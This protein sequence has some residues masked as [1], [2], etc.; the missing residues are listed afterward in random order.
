[1]RRDEIITSAV[2][3]MLRTTEDMVFIKDTDLVYVGASRAFADLVGAGSPE[4]LVGKTD[5]ELFSD[6][7]LAHRYTE[8]D[9]RLLATGGALEGY[10]EPIASKDGKPRYSRTSKYLLYDHA[11]AVIGLYG[12]GREITREYEAKLHYERELSALFELPEDALAAALFDITGWRVVDVRIRKRGFGITA[13]YTSIDDYVKNAAEAVAEEGEARAFFRSISQSGMQALYDS[14]KRNLS[15][16]YLRHTK[17]GETRWAQDDLHFLIDPVNGHLCVVVVLRDVE[18]KKRAER[19]LVRAAKQ[20]AL[21][22]L[23]NR[24]ET[25]RRIGAFL[26]QEGAHGTHAFFMIDIDNFKAVN[27]TFGHRT[28]DRVLTE[29]GEML[30]GVFRDTDIVGRIGGDEFFALMKNVSDRKT[31]LKKACDLVES[32]QYVCAV[33]QKRVELS[34]S[35]G[36]SDY[37]DGKTLEDL[38]AEADAALYRVKSSGKNGYECADGWQ[39][40][41]DKEANAAEGSAVHLKTL[42]ENIAGEVFQ[43]EVVGD[44]VRIVYESRGVIGKQGDDFWEKIVPEDR[45]RLK[46]AMYVAA[47]ADAALDDTYRVLGADGEIE[48]RY[49][50]GSKLPDSRDGVCRMINVAIDVTSQKR[51]ENALRE[52]NQIIEFAMKNTD[53]NLWFYDVATRNCLLSENCKRIHGMGADVLPNYPESIIES[54]YVREDCVEEVRE[55]YRRLCEYGEGFEMDAW[56]RTG[57]GGS[58]W[59]ERVCLA[60]VKDENGNVKT[61]IGIGKNVTEMRELENKYRAFQTYRRLAGKNTI[62]SFRMNL[63]TNWCGDCVSDKPSVQSMNLPENL[64][65]FLDL[66]YQRIQA[67]EDCARY[68]DLFSRQRLLQAF[69]DGQTSV[70]LECRYM[71]GKDYAFW[72]RSEAEMMKNPVTGDV[73]GLLY[74]SNIDYEKNMKFVMDRLVATDYGCLA[75]M[76]AETGR[77]QVLGGSVVGGT[78]S[79]DFKRR[80]YDDEM[81]QALKELLPADFYE[82]SVCKMSLGR[83]AKE[84]KAKGSY[85]YSFPAKSAP[86]EYNKRMQWKYSYLDEQ[87]TM[88]LIACTDITD[89]FTA[90]RDSLTGLYHRQAFYRHA[91]E[92]LEENP[93]CVFVML[94]FD[95]DRFKTYNDVNGTKAGDRLLARIGGELRKARFD[96]PAVCGHIDADHF[97]VL[98]SKEC[99]E[100]KCRSG[101]R[102]EWLEDMTDGYRLAVSVGIYEITEPGIDVSQMCDRALLALL[103]VKDSYKSKIMWY[104]DTMRKKLRDEQ[105]LLDE[106]EEALLGGA[107]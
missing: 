18:E 47:R 64:D 1:M 20:D 82:E 74:Y 81:Q 80:F 93:G 28:G 86:G 107:V 52:K 98:L 59:C 34:G 58:W 29:I 69:L 12:I 24:E 39:G 4:E 6:L 45:Q 96:G 76:E 10:V 9:K 73:E 43:T 41:P 101:K 60:V 66:P 78:E 31:I 61:A 13:A 77:M 23:L 103:T 92:T 85:L 54:G 91:R 55:A 21:T 53:I 104:D 36:I 65:A 22:G 14:G 11:G 89:A 49:V 79:D 42:V 100:Q 71:T 8:D 56:Y 83:V 37:R 16:T 35:V 51:A 87:K 30:R 68:R 25:M 70:S 75:L 88:I 105:M 48:W 15:F 3:A 2:Y 63:S 44:D 99:C 90:E 106:M 72:L 94:R 84:L 102:A 32:L 40:E 95:I 27:D 67:E 26:Q 7:A 50:R 17:K 62:A 46:E 19:E 33:G 97:C 38:Y 57:D 5:F